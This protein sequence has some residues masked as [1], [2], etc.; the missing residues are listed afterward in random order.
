MTPTDRTALQRL[1]ERGSQDPTV[2]KR[3]LD[4]A[5][6]AHVGFYAQSQTY[7]IP[8]IY[9]R[10]GEVLYLHGSTSSRLLGGLSDRKDACVTVTLIDGLVLAR[11]AFH[12]SVNY[13]SVVA[14]GVARALGDTASKVRAM[15]VISEH[16]MAGRWR[17]VRGPT[18]AEVGATSVI[19]FTITEASAKVREGPPVDDEEDYTRTTW[20]GVMPF[21][22]RAGPLL[23][24]P[25]LDPSISV[26]EYLLARKNPG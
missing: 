9:G 13:R 18:R 10:E 1:P 23:P 20:A 15:N 19:E 3:V 11:S 5:F 7:V 17:D 12:H 22:F 8:M 14:F 16:I 25:R 21:A 4:A 26:P 6:V 2:V 24:D